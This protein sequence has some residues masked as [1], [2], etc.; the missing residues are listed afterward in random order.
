MAA[1]RPGG[2]GPRGPAV[3]SIVTGMFVGEVKRGV[4][5]EIG[6]IEAFLPKSRFGAADRL[7]EAMYGDPL[8]VE[9]V[10]NDAGR[11]ELSRV[12]IDRSMRQPR[13]R[14]GSIE[15]RDGGVVLVPADGGDTLPVIVLDRTD[16]TALE[17]TSR[18]WLVG[19]PL[20]GHQF[21]LPADA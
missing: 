10:T 4:T 8:T 18:S 5:I 15:R 19:A 16:I 7:D 2:R 13:E 21:V 20:K 17:R 11:I 1:K 14:V 3:G 6:S 9:V 12:A